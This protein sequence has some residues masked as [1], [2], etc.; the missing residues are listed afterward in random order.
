MSD[1]CNPTE[2][3]ALQDVSTRANQV[4]VAPGQGAKT[5]IVPYSINEDSRVPDLAGQTVR[6]A[7]SETGADS[8][9]SRPTVTK[10][11][12][13]VPGT[14]SR[15]RKSGSSLEDDTAGGPTASSKPAKRA[16][17]SGPATTDISGIHLPGEE[18]DSVPVYDTCDEVRRK[19]EAHLKTPGLTQAQFCRDLYAQ[20]HQPSCK[21]FQS[22]VLND[23]RRKRGP[24]EG[25]SSSIFYAAYVYFEK[26]RIAEGKPKSE[27]RLEMERR[28]AKYGGFDREH[29]G[30]TWYTVHVDEIM[31]ENK[32]GEIEFIRNNV[33]IFDGR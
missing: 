21:S 1:V 14:S 7:T 20:L 8:L 22:K 16:A 17:K 6:A 15:K 30:R 33:S 12:A 5:T 28:W 11:A 26:K 2:R 25:C 18:T 9:Q 32:Y 4:P 29:D 23:F 19:I 24:R 13:R 31:R 3:G 10:S 27:D